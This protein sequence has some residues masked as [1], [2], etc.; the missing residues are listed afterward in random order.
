MHSSATVYAGE[1]LW[2]GAHRREL[3]EVNGNLQE[4]TGDR[5]PGSMRKTSMHEVR[6]SQ[7]TIEDVHTN[8]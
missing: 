7:K 8:T 6:L 5:I 2:S 4:N 1:G 3:F